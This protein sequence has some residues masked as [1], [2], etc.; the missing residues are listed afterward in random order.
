VVSAVV[1]AFNA[2]R[3]LDRCLGSVLAAARRHGGVE[4]IVVDNGS[5]DGTWEELQRREGGG[6][7]VLRAPG[8]TIS[9]VR[10][11][12]AGAAKGR[13]LAFIDADCEVPEDYFAT[14]ER[15]FAAGDR[16]VSGFPYALP[17]EPHWV[18]ATW[19]R[20]HHRRPPHRPKYLPGGNLVVAREAF[21]RVGGFDGSLIT[22]E[23]ADLC[24]RLVGSGA[25]LRADPSI[26]A[27]HH[28]NPKSLRAFIRKQAWH[29]IGSGSRGAVSLD[30]PNTMALAHGMCAV[31]TIV[32]AALAGGAPWPVRLALLAAGQVLV[33]LLAVGFRLLQGGRTANL[34]AAVLLYHL[35]LDVRLAVAAAALLDRRRTA[36]L[37]RGSALS[38]PSDPRR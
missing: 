17:H 28:G 4:V 35:Y 1:P 13:Y 37:L 19:Q 38:T 2:L 31:G 25:R 12:G 6:L 26:V 29:S 36:D 32:A 9:T 15:A 11:H 18:E 16:D 20:L 14:A 34:P 30:L 5:T 27:F 10:N 23:D 22:G 21:R 8:V 24:A 3:F 33:P 7:R